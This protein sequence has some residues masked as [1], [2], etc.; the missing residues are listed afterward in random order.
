MVKQQSKLEQEGFG[1]KVGQKLKES[2]LKKQSKKQGRLPPGMSVNKTFENSVPYQ[3]VH[4]SMGSMGGTGGEKMDIN[5]VIHNLLPQALQKLGIK[6]NVLPKSLVDM[7]INTLKSKI[8]PNDN[9]VKNI[10]N[11]TKAIGPLIGMGYM[12]GCGRDPQEFSNIMKKKTNMNEYMG[13][14]SKHVINGMAG[15][16][17][18]GGA[19]YD[20]LWSGVKKVL[21]PIRKVLRPIATVAQ[22]VP[23][24]APFATAFNVGD[25]ALSAVER[26][27]K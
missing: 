4:F 20:T 24:L 14:I 11:I 7:V 5:S 21:N 8:N 15:K 23:T 13:L 22:F 12:K 26:L 27:E 25:T 10:E 6:P 19:W 16:N 2:L 9:L 17:Q 3:S 1:K 18:L